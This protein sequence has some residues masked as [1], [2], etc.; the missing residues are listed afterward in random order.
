MDDFLPFFEGDCREEKEL[1][2]KHARIS[3]SNSDQVV[4]GVP[5][6]CQNDGSYLYLLTP[7]LSPPSTDSVY[8]W[9]LCDEKG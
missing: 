7:V 4:I 6:H 1:M 5:T 8:R 2:D 3:D 9:L